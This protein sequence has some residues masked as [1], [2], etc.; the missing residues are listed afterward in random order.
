MI[1]FQPY[2]RSSDEEIG[3]GYRQGG[4]GGQDDIREEQS[5]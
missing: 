5:G 3:E 2:Q 1:E 4:E